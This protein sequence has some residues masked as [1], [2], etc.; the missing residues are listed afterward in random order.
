MAGARG[1]RGGRWRSA[2]AHRSLVEFVALLLVEL[3]LDAVHELV[4]DA[5]P[6][7]EVEPALVVPLVRLDDGAD[8]LGG[9]ARV[10]AQPRGAREADPYTVGADGRPVR[11]GVV[12]VVAVPV[13]LVIRAHP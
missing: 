13:V 5:L 4:V 12:G 2:R 7:L 3:V 8:Q 10:D 1:A 6:A 11:R 9:V